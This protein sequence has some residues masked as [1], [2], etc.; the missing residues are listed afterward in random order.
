MARRPARRPWGVRPATRIMR[1][2]F[3]AV[4]LT[5]AVA[6]AQA[7]TTGESDPTFTRDIVPILQRSSPAL[8]R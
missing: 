6:T 8:P 2:V 7:P 1:A 3:A 5:S 4:V